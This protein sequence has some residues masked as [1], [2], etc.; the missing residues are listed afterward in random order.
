MLIF[1]GGM[2]TGFLSSVVRPF[3]SFVESP[4]CPFIGSRGG[5]DAGGAL[6]VKFID[7]CRGRCRDV[8][9]EWPAIPGYRDDVEEETVKRLRTLW[10][11][12]LAFLFDRRLVEAGSRRVDDEWIRSSPRDCGV[13]YS[14]YSP[15]R[16]ISD[17]IV[18]GMA[19]TVTG[20]HRSSRDGQ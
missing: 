14:S 6:G 4:A 5:R 13:R 9:R 1:Y 15:S 12:S 18:P 11:A 8:P 20:F 3:S 17:G 2:V 16:V 19:R 7:R 10:H